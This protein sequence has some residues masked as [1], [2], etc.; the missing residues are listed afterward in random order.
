METASK[1][2]VL[3]GNLINL[4]E[5]VQ[6]WGIQLGLTRSATGDTDKL[7]CFEIIQSRKK[8]AGS[9]EYELL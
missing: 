1:Q 4:D 5:F 3:V 2:A 7:H 8:F 9:P 6:V